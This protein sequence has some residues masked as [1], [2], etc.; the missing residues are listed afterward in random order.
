[1]KLAS[2]VALVVKNP[3]ASSGDAKD[4]GSITELG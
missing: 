3:H 4:L 2:L 1:M